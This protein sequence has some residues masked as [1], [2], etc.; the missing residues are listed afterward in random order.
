MHELV[1]DACS[2]QKISQGIMQIREQLAEV[3]FQLTLPQMRWNMPPG[4]TKRQK[5]TLVIHAA[6]ASVLVLHGLT[7]RYMHICTLCGVGSGEGGALTASCFNLLVCASFS[8]VGRGSGNFGRRRLPLFGRNVLAH[9]GTMPMHTWISRVVQRNGYPTLISFGFFCLQ[10]RNR[11][12]PH[13]HTHTH[14]H[15]QSDTF[16]M[17]W[18][19]ALPL[20]DMDVVQAGRRQGSLRDNTPTQ[21]TS[22]YAF[23]ACQCSCSAWTCYR[24]HISALSQDICGHC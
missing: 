16:G 5:N 1:T 6:F 14:T 23:H 15:T 19:Y 10:G 24:T 2:A 17:S 4:S 9:A 20:G 7:W 3:S 21:A 12:K 11:L 22:I 8:G 13:T 18:F